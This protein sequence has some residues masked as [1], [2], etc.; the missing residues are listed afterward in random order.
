MLYPLKLYS[1]LVFL[2]YLSDETDHANLLM[3]RAFYSSN[4]SFNTASNPHLLGF[5]KYLRP[6]FRPASPHLIRNTILN[7]EYARVQTSI[8]TQIDEAEA[9]GLISDGW[10]D[11]NN[12][13]IVNFIIIAQNLC[14][15]NLLIGGPKE[16]LLS[17]LQSNGN[18]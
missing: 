5:L 4:F 9:L 12:D 15:A 2:I 11:T 6:A 13:G 17:M 7:K 10:T 1:N 3:A 16:R 8:K 14:S 18:L